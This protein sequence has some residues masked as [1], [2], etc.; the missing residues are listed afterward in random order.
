MVA[1]QMQDTISPRELSRKFGCA[2]LCQ[3][4]FDSHIA[5]FPRRP[6]RFHVCVRPAIRF[7]IAIPIGITN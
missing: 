6:V 2:K 3:V 7:E 5:E 4:F 1:Q